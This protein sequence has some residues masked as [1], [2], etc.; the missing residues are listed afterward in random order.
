M[1]N[2]KLTLSTL[3]ISVFLLSGFNSNAQS[4]SDDTEI[5]IQTSAVCG[6]CKDR[7]EET[8]A[9][10]EGVKEAV[11]DMN[12]KIV[13]V[14]YNPKK[15]DVSKIKTAINKIGYDADET[16]A[17]PDAYAKLPNCCKKDGSKKCSQ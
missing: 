7:I 5:K 6:M 12:T 1:K 2:F 14:T 13:S 11:L 10:E 17:N 9:Y 16:K 15:T 3:I 8:L 4:K